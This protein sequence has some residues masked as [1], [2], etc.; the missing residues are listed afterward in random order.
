MGAAIDRNSVLMKEMRAL[1]GVIHS[2]DLAR[3]THPGDERATEE[4][5]KI[6]GDFGAQ[7]A[8]PAE[9]G[10]EMLGEAETAEI[11]PRKDMDMV[12]AL[13]AAQER[14]PLG[15]DDPGDPGPGAGV[16]EKGCGGQRV[17]NV[18]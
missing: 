1:A 9:P 2:I 15:I 18:T 16:A 5:L 4:A 10:K 11:A 13:I 8:H 17:H 3:V 6:K 14:R 7:A 12:D